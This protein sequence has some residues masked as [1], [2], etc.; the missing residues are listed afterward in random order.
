MHRRR[1]L[2]RSARRPREHGQSTVE[3]A[4]V[5]P[6]VLLVLVG[7]VQLALVVH[8]ANVVTT[9]AQEG[10]RYAAAEGRT[11]TDGTVRAEEVLRSG[12]GADADQLRVT[13]RRGGEGV[14]VQI[15]GEYRLLLV[16]MT[17]RT[18]P[19]RATAEMRREEFRAGP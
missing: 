16:W 6:L 3:L 15:E 17:G 18:I 11:P 2:L 5:L 1:K 9:A 13:T 12:L 8:A 14:S 10:A 19:L 4:V 7:V